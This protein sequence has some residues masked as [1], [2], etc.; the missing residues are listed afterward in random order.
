MQSTRERIIQTL[1]V[2]PRSTIIEIAQEVGINAISVRHHI[3]SLQ[4]SAMVAAEEERHGVGRPRMVYYLTEK[5]MEH[6]PT[7]YLRL[8]NNL[9]SQ[10]KQSISPE[11]ITVLFRKMA[12]KTAGEYKSSLENLG[13]EQK[14][15]ILKEVMQKEGFNIR[16]RPSD[17][18]Y[19]INEI[20]C[21]YFRV[22]KLH[23]EVCVFDKTLIADILSIPT[24]RIQTQHISDAICSF[25]ITP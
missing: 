21:P 17:D 23:P 16:W 22:G 5:G 15:E 25:I 7:S 9:L 20:S 4:A 12:Y 2:H 11:E 24:D 3:T 8:T 1:S 13:L 19:I 18:H 6:F 10:L 14:L